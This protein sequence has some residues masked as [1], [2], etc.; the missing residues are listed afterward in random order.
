MLRRHLAGPDL[1]FPTV[2]CSLTQAGRA[3]QGGRQR[4][5][6]LRTLMTI[7]HGCRPL[8]R[9]LGRRHS[10]LGNYG[11]DWLVTVPTAAHPMT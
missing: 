9:A 11:V 1:C 6:S 5:S 2:P 7:T 4:H 8:A 10:W 3:P